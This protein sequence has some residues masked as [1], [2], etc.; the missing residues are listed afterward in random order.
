MRVLVC[1]S[2]HW[3]DPAPIRAALA[4]L[5]ADTVIVHGAAPGADMLAAALAEARGLAVE[6]HP[7]EWATYGRRAGPLRNEAML[8]TG[9]D[10]VVAFRLPGASPGTDHMVR[11]ARAARIPTEVI[12]AAPTLEPLPPKTRVVHC[13]CASYDVYIGRGPG[14]VWGNPFTF[15]PGTSAPHVV[16]TREAAVEAYRLWLLRQ[17]EL[18]ARVKE[19]R[20]KVLG[21]WCKPAACHGDI[22]ARLADLPE[23]ALDQLVTQARRHAVLSGSRWDGDIGR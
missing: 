17:P 3:T 21:C 22:L 18:L 20:G 4:P 1:G 6:P 2:R 7:A 15:K 13:K 10:R 12:A 19:L 11:M 16:A 9:I 23:V 8:A 14:S 5:P